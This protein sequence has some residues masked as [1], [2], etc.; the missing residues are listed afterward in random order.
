MAI[1]A[2]RAVSVTT[3]ATR[4]DADATDS[5]SGLKVTVVAQ[6]AGTLVLGPSGVTAANGARFAVVAGTVLEQPL[7]AGESLYGIVASG[8]LEVD[9]L[10]S[11]A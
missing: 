9:V 5:V 7:E 2:R 10:L 4:I 1:V 3:S 8:T 6:G 11:G